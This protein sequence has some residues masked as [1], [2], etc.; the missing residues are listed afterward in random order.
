MGGGAAYFEPSTK[1]AM[2]VPLRASTGKLQKW[3]WFIFLSPNF[4]RDSEKPQVFF[5]IRNKGGTSMHFSLVPSKGVKCNGQ[6]V[7]HFIWTFCD[8]KEMDE[9]WEMKGCQYAIYPGEDNKIAVT[10]DNSIYGVEINSVESPQTAMEN[11]EVFA[12]DLQ[13][14]SLGNGYSGAIDHFVFHV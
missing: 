7:F 5:T 14:W 3:K 10:V 1:I 2:K 4:I 11:E 13:T 9:I 8:G 12:L 6:S